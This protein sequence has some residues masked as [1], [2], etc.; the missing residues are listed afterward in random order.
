M[1][2]FK[3]LDFHEGESFLTWVPDSRTPA[4][5]WFQIEI[6]SSVCALY[7]PK[8]LRDEGFVKIISIEFRK[9]SSKNSS[10][11]SWTVPGF[12]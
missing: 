5:D 9:F 6:Q 10:L 8:R 3:T 12:C 2:G 4:A 11:A 7:F 1:R